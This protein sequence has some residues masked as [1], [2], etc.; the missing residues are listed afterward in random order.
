MKCLRLGCLVLVVLGGLVACRESS[1]EFSAPRKLT[2]EQRPTRWDAPDRQ[3][4]SVQDPTS[5]PGGS[6]TRPSLSFTA[7]TVPGFESQPAQPQR[8]RDMVWRI[9]GEAA[10]ECYLTAFVGGSAQ[11]NVD[12]WYGQMGQSPQPLASLPRVPM[13]GDNGY[14][15]ELQGSLS[16]VAE[17]AMA[18][19]F[20]VRDGGVT[21]LKFTGPAAIVQQHRAGFLELA[22]SLRESRS[23]ADSRAARAGLPP[24][25]G[26]PPADAQHA[27]VTPP[28][29]TPPA[30]APH[31]GSAAHA[32]PFAAQIP[33]S[34]T[35]KP[36]S[37]RALHHAFGNDGDVYVGQMGGGSLR[38]MLD[39]WRGEVGQGPA[40]DAEFAA[41]PAFEL[42]GQPGKFLDV[43]G[44]FHSMS[45]RRIPNAR[46]LVAACEHEGS[47]LFVKLVGVA[48][49]VANEV[50]PFRTFC[51]SLR[52]NP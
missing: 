30:V 31:G 12:R 10:T 11:Q 3:R 15:L 7:A 44:E 25:T 36:G 14:L 19:A 6:K 1:A 52:R 47:I 33:A 8:F 48:T 23:E 41:V 4:L 24:A 13:A 26:V 38:Q 27:G 34:W 43:T 49:D 37:M 2:A 20:L 51:A 39:I 5:G 50:E 42:L 28:A 21:T 40:S 18:I 46:V 22:A 35:A 32:A 9:A 17:Q 45:N 16:G 29:V